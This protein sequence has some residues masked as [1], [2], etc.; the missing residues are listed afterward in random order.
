H[1]WPPGEDTVSGLSVVGIQDAHSAKENRHLRGGQRQQLRPINQQLLRR[2]GVFGFEVVTEPVCSRLEYGE[3]RH[4]GLLL[5]RIRA[6]RREGNGHC[7]AGIPRGLLDTCASA[8]D[9][10]V[11]ERNPL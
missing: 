9:D 8:K 4:V 7:K 6:S 11:G 2:Y 1:L 3:R 5:R 10:Q